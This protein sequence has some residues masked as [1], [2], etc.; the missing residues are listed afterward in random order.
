MTQLAIY[1]AIGFGFL[2]FFVADDFRNG[3]KAQ[4]RDYH[5]ILL[6]PLVALAAMVLGLFEISSLTSGPGGGWLRKPQRW[7]Q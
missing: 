1:L 5:L 7:I 6:W 4:S 2:A 3:R